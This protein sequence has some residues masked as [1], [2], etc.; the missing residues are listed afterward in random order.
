[1]D[2]TGQ[3]AIDF[4]HDLSIFVREIM[5]LSAV[6]NYQNDAPRLYS[7]LKAINGMAIALSAN[8]KFLEYVEAEADGAELARISIRFS[9]TIIR[10][11]YSA[12]YL[13]KIY[14]FSGAIR[15]DILPCGNVEGPDVFEFIPFAILQN[16][17]KYSPSASQIQLSVSGNSS[18][19][20]ARF[21]SCGPMI[22]DSEIEKIFEKGYR[23]IHTKQSTV[24]GL[25]LGLY[26]AR[27]GVRELF[28]GDIT[29]KRQLAP[30]PFH[31]NGVTHSMHEFL[32]S[33]PTT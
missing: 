21:S 17:I 13:S 27:R 14:Q 8:T 5:H 15:K 19:V 7:R 10:L 29:V 12:E 33:V 32:L 26:Y 6:A 4:R 31:I 20:Y 24:S 30:P 28:G 9:S 25:G 2:N 23:G 18:M 22:E 1:M 3:L 16:C 11:L